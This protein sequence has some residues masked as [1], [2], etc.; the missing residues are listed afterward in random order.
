MRPIKR[1]KGEESEM[2]SEDIF[3]TATAWTTFYGQ[4]LK[5]IIDEIGLPKTLVLHRKHGENAGAM[6]ASELKKLGAFN[7]EALGKMM[8]QAYKPMGIINLEI[9][10]TP[11]SL[12]SKNG[13][14]PVY[15]GFKMAGLDDETIDKLCTSREGAVM[16]TITEA[17]PGVKASLTR[18]KPDGY[19]ESVFKV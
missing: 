16:A 14:C 8:E 13:K 11:N 7:P 4:L 10:A 1:C 12:V 6:F 2:S 3:T 17:F 5:E 15:E 18:D 9:E 19:C